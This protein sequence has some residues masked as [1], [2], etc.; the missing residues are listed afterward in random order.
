MIIRSSIPPTTPPIIAADFK[1]SSAD[2]PLSGL[3]TCSR[4][5]KICTKKYSTCSSLTKLVMYGGEALFN[6]LYTTIVQLQHF[7]RR[8]QVY[9]HNLVMW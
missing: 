5:V 4:T 7:V 8:E 1:T 6:D 9:T 3:E 2:F